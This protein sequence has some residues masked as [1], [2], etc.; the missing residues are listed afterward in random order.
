MELLYTSLSFQMHVFCY[1]LMATV[2]RPIE[3]LR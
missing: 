2:A 1:V 3:A